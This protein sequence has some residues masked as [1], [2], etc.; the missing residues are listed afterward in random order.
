MCKGG[1]LEGKAFLV[2]NLEELDLLSVLSKRLRGNGNQV[3]QQPSN[4][5]NWVKNREK[6]N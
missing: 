5:Y 1:L 3:L 2:Q 6:P 4:R